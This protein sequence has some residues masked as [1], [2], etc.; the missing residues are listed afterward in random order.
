MANKKINELTVRTP[1]LSDLMIVGDPSSGYSFKCTV[2]ALATIIETDIADGFVTIATAQTISGAKTFSN[3]VTLTS[4]A[5]SPSVGSK[6]LILNASNVINYRT[7]A[8]VLS[9]IGGQGTLTLTTTGTSGAATLVA[10][11]LNIPQYQA[12]LSGTGIVKSTSGTISYLTD[13]STNWNSAYDNMIVSAA[14][15]GSTTKT[16]TLTQQDSGTITASWTDDNT[17]TVTS[18]AAT[19][20]TGISVSGSPITSSG[21]LTI[22]NTA[23][24]Q[25]VVLTAG[26]G[27]SVSGTYPNFTITNSSPSSGGTVT[28]VAALTLGT[29]GTD[30]SSSVAN[31][32]TTPVITLNVPTAS[33]TNRGALSST[34]WSTFNS[35]QS[36]ITLTTTGSSGSATFVSNTLN[37]PTYTLAGLGGISGSGTTNYI[38]KFTSSSAIGNSNLQTDA[39]GNLGLG[40]TPSAWGSAWKASQVQGYSVSTLG[41]A[42]ADIS[43]NA[44]NDNNGWLYI[45]SD[46]ATQYRQGSGIHKWYTAPSGT[47]GNAISFTQAMTLDASGRLGVGTTSPATNLDVTGYGRATAGFVGGASGLSL[48]SDVSASTAGVFLGTNQRVGIGTT[49]PA[50]LLH[51][52][53]DQNAYTW[54]R[55]DN[56]ANNAAAYAGLQ[57]A[58]YGNTWGISIGSSLANSNALSFVIDAGGGNTERMRITSGGN[59][60][61]GKTDTS[62]ASA[63]TIIYPS[64][65]LDVIRNGN[66]PLA[67]NRLTSEGRIIDLYVAGTLAGSI[68]GLSATGLIFNTGT[69]ERMR[70]T[71]GGNVGIGTSSPTYKLEVSDGTRVGLINPRSSTSG[72]GLSLGTDVASAGNVLN[73]TGDLIGGGTGGGVNVSYY[74]SAS[75]TWNAALSIRNTTSTYSNLL[76]MQEGG[77][78]G[79]GTTSPATLLHLQQSSGP[80]IR[81]VRSSNRFDITGDT[82]FMELNAR[83]ASTY[84]IFKTADTERMRITS[85][86]ELLINTTSDAGD[87][88]LQVNGNGYFSGGLNVNSTGTEM[89]NITNVDNSSKQG[90]RLNNGINASSGIVVFNSSSSTGTETGGLLRIHQQSSSL[91]QPTAVLRQDGSADIL[92]LQGSAGSTKFTFSSAGNFENTGSI[93]TAAPSGGTAKPYKL[94]EAG[95]A[96]GGSDGYAVK[97]EIDGTLYYL[98]TGYLP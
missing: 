37:V 51:T 79:I 86:G 47:A 18:V 29:T 24:D 27:I 59:V 63:G 57:L 84:M 62:F 9:D 61:V 39:S 68:G 4:V 38:P 44:Y 87:Y 92:Q 31:G 55:I 72:T 82:D 96:I 16:L 54:A 23:P 90:I 45:G 40:V 88:K 36:A 76:L 71:S 7:A 74:S 83:D 11:T 30:L 60:L 35:K 2:T 13:N 5:N 78:V 89:F 70:I 80:T 26:T 53:K 91:S 77:N 12:V 20:G 73:L 41:N 14:V 34:D 32:T 21:T 64:S 66:P 81:L 98:M 3:I 56:Q 8:E 97:V 67:L 93:K 42:E 52:R 17:G 1:A 58:A 15:S 75:S 95:V 49:D 25:T 65:G 10:N 46:Y 69:S 48:W 94:G 6:F 33:A 50:Q 85:G 28:S 43:L 22:T 19:G